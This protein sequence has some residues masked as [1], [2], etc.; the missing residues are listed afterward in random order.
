M[1]DFKQNKHY[2][3]EDA[4]CRLCGE[5]PEDAHHVVNVCRQMPDNCNRVI[6]LANCNEESAK[7]IIRRVDAFENLIE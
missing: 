2:K 3:Y 7:E 1:Y 4:H 6:N 5:E